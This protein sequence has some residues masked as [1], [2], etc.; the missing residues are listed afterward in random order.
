[1]DPLSVALWIVAGIL[2][3]IILNAIGSRIMRRRYMS[4]ARREAAQAISDAEREAATILKEAQTELKEQRIELR[5]EVEREA[6]EQRRELVALEKRILAKEESVD[7][8]VELLETKANEVSAKERDLTKREQALE[9]RQEEIDRIIQEQRAKLES[10]SGMSAEQARRELFTQLENEVRRDTALR[11]KRIED[12]LVENS[13]K[14]AQWVISQA[15]QRCAADHVAESTVSVVDLPNDE[16]K[17]R[18]IGREGRNIRALESVTGINII[19]DDTPEAVILSGFDPIR[20]EVARI[21]LERLIQDGRIHPARIEE[22]VAKVQEEMNQTIKEL[23]EAACLETGVHGL[24]P[25]IVKL[26]GRLNYR[27]SYGQNVLRHAQE[28]CHLAGMMA[29]ELGLNVQEAKR[30]ALIHDIGKAVTHEVE[31]SHAAIG[32]DFARRYGESPNIVNAIGA[33]HN[34]QEKQSVMA[35]L[36]Q[37]ADALSAAR[38]GARRETIESYV[39]RLEQLEALANGFEGVEKSYALQA[40]REVRLAVIPEK[41]DDAQAAQLARDVARKVEQEMTY[42]GQ[43]RVTV[44]R[45]TRASETAN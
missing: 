42:P 10:V 9:N 4:K 23:G 8:R 17:G 5:A 41:V 11:L 32:A 44:I 7:K 36:V 34:E 2:I 35:V 40:G 29:A 22:V 20:R 25:E 19:I 16:M 1:M 18:I 37:A 28:V 14:R 6:R 24:H 13:E 3:G 43:I 12:E 26:L 39:K 30:A 21:T 15:I 27:T 38:P 33:H 45:E 31:G